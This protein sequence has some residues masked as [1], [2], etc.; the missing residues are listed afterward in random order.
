MILEYSC[1]NYKSIKNEIVFSMLA[2]KDTSMKNELLR[3]CDVSI[4][5]MACILGPNGSGKSNFIKSLESLVLLIKTSYNAQ[6]GDTLI[7]QRHKSSLNEPT[8]YSIHFITNNIRYYYYLSYTDVILEEKLYYYPNDKKTILFEREKEELKFGSNNQRNFSNAI[9]AMRA[10]PIRLFI[11]CAANL[12]DNKYIKDAFLFFKEKL[13]FYPHMPNNWK[14]YTIQQIRNNPQMKDRFI[15]FLQAI[16][17]AV[18][19]ID[20]NE[21]INDIQPEIKPPFMTPVIKYYDVNINHGQFMLS[22]NEESNGFKKLFE[23]LCPLFSIIEE[24]RILLWDEFETNLHP[25]IIYQIINIFKRLE[26]NNNSQFIFTTHFI[27][28]LDLNIMRRDQIWFTELDKESL[29]TILFSLAEIKN[30][31]KEENI[32]KGYSLNRYGGVPTIN[33]DKIYRLVGGIVND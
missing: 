29:S 30:V 25:D 33:S 2:S 28:V 9:E 22:L 18:Q 20:I 23:V 16:D 4:L 12:N 19:D 5:R 24:Q 14:E 8:E 10:N 32:S 3:F 1:K 11:S 31:R 26:T 13:V 7:N 27:N 17:L 21:R 6:P 15:T